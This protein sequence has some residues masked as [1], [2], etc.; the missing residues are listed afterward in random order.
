MS[1]LAAPALLAAL[2]L[3]ATLAACGQ[4]GPPRRA[5]SPVTAAAVPAAAGELECSDDEEQKP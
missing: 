1:R 3:F 4:Y 2:G 5:D